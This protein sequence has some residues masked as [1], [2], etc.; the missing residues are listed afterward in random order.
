LDEEGGIKI[1]IQ[2]LSKAME[3]KAHKFVTRDVTMVEKTLRGKTFE[4]KKKELETI[5]AVP[6]PPQ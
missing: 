3:K 5:R 2:T 4:G 6:Q 1:C